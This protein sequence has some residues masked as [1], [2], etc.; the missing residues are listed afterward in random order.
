MTDGSPQAKHWELLCT[1]CHALDTADW[2]LL[3]SILADDV[4]FSANLMRGGQRGPDEI[5]LEGRE[6]MVG[7]IS[8]IWENLSATHHMISNHLVELDPG[9]HS[10]RGS[11][12]IRA[13][14]AGAGERAHLFEESLGRFDFETVLEGSKWKIQGW[15][16]NIMIMLG[17]PEVFGHGPD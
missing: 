5:R 1:Y 4:V 16:E 15:D 3:G 14:H 12:Y 10:A 7:H 2:A 17:T 9:G 13:Y 6:A 11:C 8:G